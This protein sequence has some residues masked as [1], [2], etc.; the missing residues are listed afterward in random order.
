MTSYISNTLLEAL[1]EYLIENGIAAGRTAFESKHDEGRVGVFSASSRKHAD[2]I[3]MCDRDTSVWCMD[4]F[5]PYSSADDFKQCRAHREDCRT[6]KS[7]QNAFL[8]PGVTEFVKSLPFF[9][10]TGKV[11]I[12][13][14]KANDKGVEHQDHDLDDLGELACML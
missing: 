9:S 3:E 4:T 11:A 5:V 12:I 14:N 2:A 10:S 8:L 13:I 6:W 1:D 7:N